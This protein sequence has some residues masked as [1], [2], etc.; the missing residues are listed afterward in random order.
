[1]S[2]KEKEKWLRYYGALE[3]GMKEVRRSVVITPSRAT[4][5]P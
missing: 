4:Y 2:K 1:M 5:L 3:T